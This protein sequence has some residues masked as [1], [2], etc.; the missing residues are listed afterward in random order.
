MV[1][2]CNVHLDIHKLFGKVIVCHVLTGACALN[3]QYGS[4]IVQ[5]RQLVSIIIRL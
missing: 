1:K 5:V 3:K 2:I 4:L